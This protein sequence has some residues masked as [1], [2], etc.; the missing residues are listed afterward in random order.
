MGRSLER[1][2]GSAPAILQVAVAATAAYAFGHFLLGHAM[3]LF[4]VTVTISSLGLS[5]DARP[6]RVLET[7]AAITLGILL[8]DLLLLGIGRGWW[9]LFLVL[10][11]TLAA[12][13]LLSPNVA[14]AVAAAV[15]AA[16]VALFPAPGGDELSRAVD[17]LVGGAVALLATALL[18]RD[19]R[20][21][22]LADARRVFT[23]C[24][25][26]LAALSAALRLA[27]VPGADATLERLRRTQPL[28][29][30]WS[31]SLDSASAV[32]RISPFLRRHRGALARQRRLLRGMD[33]ACRNLRII[34]RRTDFLVRDGRP[35]L[36]L[37]ELVGAI[38]GAV[39]L[40]G[41]ALEDDEQGGLARRDL[42]SIAADLDPRL[43]L[44][45]AGI[46]ET[47]VGMLLRPLV[48]DLLAAAGMD[49]DRARAL[50]PPIEG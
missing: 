45:E 16:L 7:A 48:V 38:G 33:L 3:P 24:V 25:D 37:A 6:V 28:L 22:A 47:M 31:A 30:A 39:V 34:A 17:G 46:S 44:P 13:R 26:A 23:E 11:V 49:E 15:Q 50:L 41:G 43:L 4:A 8:A 29:D 36:A 21:Q 27:D 5:R 10:V 19:P 40:L 2:S 18:P 1:L 42:E 35:R 14:F 32:A 9:Q 12:A 20:R